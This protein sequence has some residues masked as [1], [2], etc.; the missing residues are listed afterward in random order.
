MANT[1]DYPKYYNQYTGHKY[2]VTRYNNKALL[3]AWQVMQAKIPMKFAIFNL[4]V[5]ITKQRMQKRYH[6]SLHAI[7][8]VHTN[9]S[10]FSSICVF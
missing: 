7:S 9:A 2:H 6:F 10:I 5:Y 1:Q 8:L 4:S 3:R